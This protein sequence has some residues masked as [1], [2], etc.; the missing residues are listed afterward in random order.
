[1][2]ESSPVA[3]YHIGTQLLVGMV[4]ICLWTLKL[5]DGACL[6]LCADVGC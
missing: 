5:G 2:N 4:P 6:G 3:Q 1:M